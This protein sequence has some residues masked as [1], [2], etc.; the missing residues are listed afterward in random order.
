M[1]TKQFQ[2]L[3]DAELA[4]A[5]MTDVFTPDE[6]HGPAAPFFEYALASSWQ[7][8]TYLR[9][10]RFWLDGDRP[11]GFV[12]YEDDPNRLHFT[13]RPGYEA[14]AGEMLDY[15]EKA[16]PVFDRPRELVKE[17][18]KQYA[19]TGKIDDELLKAVCSPMIPEE[20]Y[21]AIV[22]GQA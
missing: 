9:L 16:F 21:A 18:G 12:F 10:N 19:E 2:I 11:V 3:T 20:Q 6:R 8:K 22:N 13:L 14:L 4:W 1:R 15:A 5:L 7:D 17:A